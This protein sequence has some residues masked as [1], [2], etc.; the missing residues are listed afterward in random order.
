MFV[1]YGSLRWRSGWGGKVKGR[2]VALQ[3]PKNGLKTA[4]FMIFIDDDDDFIEFL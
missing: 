2:A 4:L 3:N 1:L